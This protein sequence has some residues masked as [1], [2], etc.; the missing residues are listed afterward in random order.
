MVEVNDFISKNDIWSIMKADNVPNIC[1]CIMYT[2]ANP[3]IIKVLRDTDY[4]QCFDFISNK[5]PIFALKPKPE[6]LLEYM[7]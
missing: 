5:W 6:L 3:N 2:V 1:G 7:V 4:W